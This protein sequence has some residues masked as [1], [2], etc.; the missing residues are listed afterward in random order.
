SD[1][2]C[3]VIVNG[4]VYLNTDAKGYHNLKDEFK[5]MLKEDFEK[6]EEGF[7]DGVSA[8]LLCNPENPVGKVWTEDELIKWYDREDH[9]N[10]DVC[11]DDHCQRYQG[12]TRAST[13]KVRAAITK[14]WGELLTYNGNICDARFSKCCGG[15]VE[16]FKSCWEPVNY[17]YLVPLR[18]ST[19][20]Q[21]Y[22]NLT[23]EVNAEEWIMQSPNAFCNTTNK[24][25]LGQ[26]LNNYDQETTNFYRWTQKYSQKELS[27]LILNRSG[28][29]YGEIIDLIPIERGPSGR[30]IKLKIVGTKKIMTI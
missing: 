25:I 20:S 16:E 7:K 8:F 30:L 15:V 11:A 24:N 18:D 28:I 17:K 19:K 5:V 23:I 27:N 9:V 1:R 4:K 6:I 14:T 12:L 29:D 2:K 10:F 13:P 26:V 22:P 3:Q 21:D